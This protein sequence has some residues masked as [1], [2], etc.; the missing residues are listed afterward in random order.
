MEI[1]AYNVVGITAGV[2]RFCARTALQQEG[3]PALV[4]FRGLFLKPRNVQGV[5]DGSH[6]GVVGEMQR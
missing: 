6:S 1:P 3:L 4:D 5:K 2:F